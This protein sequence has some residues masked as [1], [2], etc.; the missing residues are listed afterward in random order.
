VNRNSCDLVAERLALAGVQTCSDDDSE[1]RG[2]ESRIASAQRMAR[3]GPSNAAK[4]PSPAVS[5][6]RPRKRVTSQRHERRFQT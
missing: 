3:A 5:I 1:A 6:S 4:K 2:A